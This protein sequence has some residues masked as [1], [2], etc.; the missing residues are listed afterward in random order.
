[1][2]RLTRM[3]ETK[4][5]C[6]KTAINTAYPHNSVTIITLNGATA[7]SPFSRSNGTED[8]M[9]SGTLKCIGDKITISGIK[10]SFF[11]ENALGR[12]KVFYRIMLVKGPRGAAFGNDLFKGVTDNK[13]IDQM[14]TE[15][16]KI[17]AQKR[18]SVSASNYGANSTT[19]TGEPLE[20]LTI[21]GDYRAGIGS[22][23]VNFWIP[24][25][26]F[27]KGGNLQYEDSGS[28]N[29]KFFDY[30]WCMLVY[31][32]FGTPMAP[33]NVGRIN[34]GYSKVYFKDA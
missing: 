16:Y 7:N 1:V 20:V 15:R 29:V 2:Q 18:F 17:I 4:E 23:I 13:M 8:P 3:I 27:G 33:N 24:G 26:K 21:G 32:W 31:D 9:G 5:G 22:K 30:R 28:S 12:P 6:Y 14:N 34:E 10:A 11:L 25:S 19:L